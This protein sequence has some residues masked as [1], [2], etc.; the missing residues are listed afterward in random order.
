MLDAIEAR[1]PP[2]P[3]HSAVLGF[4]YPA[5]V[6]PEVPVFDH[7]WDLSGA[8]RLR[9][10]DASIRAFPIF[11]GVD[12]RC[13]G[14]LLIDGGAGYGSFESPYRRLYFVDPAGS[15]VVRSRSE[16]EQGLRRFHPGPLES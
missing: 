4:G 11:A 14:E 5:Q 1:L 3:H 2:L 16:C 13:G 10:D 12:V 15:T 8:L 7:N 6:A 9:A